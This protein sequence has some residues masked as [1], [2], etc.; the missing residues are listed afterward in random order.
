MNKEARTTKSKEVPISNRTMGGANKQK[1]K[2][3]ITKSLVPMSS[4]TR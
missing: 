4:K 1:N 3:S 2:N